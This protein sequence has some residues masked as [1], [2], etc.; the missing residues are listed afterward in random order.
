MLDIGDKKFWLEY[1]VAFCIMYV[2]TLFVVGVSVGIFYGIMYLIGI[3]D[4]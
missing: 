3:I 1:F 2:F 4:L